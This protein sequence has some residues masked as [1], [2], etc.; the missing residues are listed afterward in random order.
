M[1]SADRERLGI[2]H[3]HWEKASDERRLT[4]LRHILR[5]SDCYEQPL[6]TELQEHAAEE[7]P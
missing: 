3:R 6:E 5:A 4:I 1:T 7:A 2:D